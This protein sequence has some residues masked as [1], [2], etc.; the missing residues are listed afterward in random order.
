M[1]LPASRP[2]PIEVTD[3]RR[4]DDFAALAQALAERGGMTLL[5]APS[6]TTITN[7]TQSAHPTPVEVRLPG[8]AG[9]LTPVSM[10]AATGSAS[11]YRRLFTRG[12]LVAYCGA[13]V[14]GGGGAAGL[15]WLL[16]P[17]PLVAGL[18]SA[19]GVLT[20]FTGTLMAHV[21]DA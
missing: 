17:T 9:P 20:A 16:W 18:L 3:S 7:T 15:A 6:T 2:D 14:L 12:E 21:E 1:Y 11:P 8:P 13:S 4:T 19:L 10:A 5:Y